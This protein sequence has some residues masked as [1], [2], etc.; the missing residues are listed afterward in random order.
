VRLAQEPEPASIDHPTF[1]PEVETT[2]IDYP[3][4]HFGVEPS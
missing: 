1:S 2:K 3:A 4:D